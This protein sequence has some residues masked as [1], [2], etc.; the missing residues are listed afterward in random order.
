MPEET[1][2]RARNVYESIESVS[3]SYL[4]K[5]K[6]MTS[7]R[8]EV[9]GEHEEIQFSFQKRGRKK[10]F[11]SDGE[12][13]KGIARFWIFIQFS[14]NLVDVSLPDAVIGLFIGS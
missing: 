7:K 13:A 1:R 4:Q 11:I 5:M 2:H 12:S 9:R 10:L 3:I 14:C 6:L 8:V